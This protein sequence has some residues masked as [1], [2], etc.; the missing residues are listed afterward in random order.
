LNGKQKGFAWK[1]KGGAGEGAEELAG[2][3]VVA[4][5]VG[6]NKDMVRTFNGL[7]RETRGDDMEREGRQNKTIW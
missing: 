1:E 4:V 3:P 7:R 2:L 6:K 5:P